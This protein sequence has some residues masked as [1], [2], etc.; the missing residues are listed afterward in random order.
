MK[1]RGLKPK[2]NLVHDFIVEL[3][4]KQYLRNVSISNDV[5]E[6]VLFEGTLG[7]SF[8][9]SLEEGNVLEIKGKSG[10]LRVS[11]S[12]NQVKQVLEKYRKMC[13]GVESERR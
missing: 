2:D 9:L 3:D 13:V 11:V 12:E 8:E 10:V 6:S 5:R 1:V 7:E 4:S